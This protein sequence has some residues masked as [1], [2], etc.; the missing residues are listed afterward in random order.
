M[1][2]KLSQNRHR[3]RGFILQEAL[4]ATGLVAVVLVGVVHL[5]GAATQQRRAASHYARATREAANAMEQ[6]IACAW[7]ELAAE[8]AAIE[9]R[10]SAAEQLPGGRIEVQ[11]VDESPEPGRRIRIRIDWQNTAGQRVQPVQLVAWRYPP[12]TPPADNDAEGAT[13]P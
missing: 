10:D 8:A 4:M 7:D 9:R 2:F 6:L 11:I 5:M 13:E 1:K 3:R 12:V